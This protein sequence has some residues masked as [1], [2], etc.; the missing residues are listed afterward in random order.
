MSEPTQVPF[1]A[2]LAKLRER[3]AEDA[4]T[5]AVLQ[6]RID[7]LTSPAAAAPAAEPDLQA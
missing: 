5:I 6:A 3:V 2:V 1:Q 7:D 4:V